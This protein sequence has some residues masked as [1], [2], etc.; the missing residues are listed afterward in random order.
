MARR[1]FIDLYVD[2]AIAFAVILLLSAVCLSLV[3]S[4]VVAWQ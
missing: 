4:H 2:V 3:A 1:G